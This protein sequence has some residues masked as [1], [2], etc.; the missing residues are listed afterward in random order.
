MPRVLTKSR[1]G[2]LFVL[3]AYLLCLWFLIVAV[4]GRA[5]GAGWVYGRRRVLIGPHS[6]DPEVC[7]K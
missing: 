7:V 2:H 4:V 3:E 6:S 5:A 1:K